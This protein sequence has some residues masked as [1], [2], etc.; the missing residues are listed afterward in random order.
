M[1]NDE[2]LMED[3][4]GVKVA[5]VREKINLKDRLERMFSDKAIEYSRHRSSSASSTSPTNLEAHLDQNQWEF[6]LQEIDTYLQ[7]LLSLNLEEG[8]CGQDIN[9]VSHISPIE[10]YVEELKN[11]DDKVTKT[12]VNIRYHLHF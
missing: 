2:I 3:D 11:S 12:T 1:K 4:N 8:S 7:E 6:C 5:K 9:D 10:P